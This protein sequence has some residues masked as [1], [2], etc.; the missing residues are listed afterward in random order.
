MDLFVPWPAR[1]IKGDSGRSTDRAGRAI[2]QG[3]A[4]GVRWCTVYGVWCTVQDFRVRVHVSTSRSRVSS[5]SFKVWG[6][7]VWFSGSRV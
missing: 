3:M 7:R 4:C 6:F 2:P 1:Q 5:P